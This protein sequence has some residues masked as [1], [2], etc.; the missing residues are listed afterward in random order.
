[1]KNYNLL[2]IFLL[3]FQVLYL[4]IEY[5]TINSE[6]MTVF[7]SKMMY[8]R[9]FTEAKLFIVVYIVIYLNLL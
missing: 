7:M 9:F 1:M 4:M 3:I 2:P 6:T 8:K 5:F